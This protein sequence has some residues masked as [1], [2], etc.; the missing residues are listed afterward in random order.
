[1]SVYGNVPAEAGVTL[2][3]PELACVPLH[4]PEAVQL[5]A[6]VVDQVSVAEEPSVIGFGATDKDE[7]AGGA[8]TVTVVLPDL[9][10]SCA[11]VAVTV[12]GPADAGAVNKPEELMVPAFTVQVTVE[13]KLPVPAT[14][15]VHCEVCPV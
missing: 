4:A 1:V 14:V 13:L 8:A 12:T 9:L 10:V 6:F 3:V 7:I 2:C 5:A 15:A 11:D